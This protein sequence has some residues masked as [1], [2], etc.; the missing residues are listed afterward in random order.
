LLGTALV[1]IFSHTDIGDIGRH[2]L[3]SIITEGSNLTT[4][5]APSRRTPKA[6][7][8]SSRVADCI[9]PLFA[10]SS[11]NVELHTDIAVKYGWRQMDGDVEL[12]NY[13]Y[14]SK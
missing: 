7:A 12:Y 1:A 4:K 8:I 6:A 14:G 3:S 10:Q 5:A 13:L 9:Q 11:F 2:G